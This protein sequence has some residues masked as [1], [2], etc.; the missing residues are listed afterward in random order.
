MSDSTRY[1]QVVE[2][3]GDE[4]S[5]TYLVGF[6]S[7]N[8][9]EAMHWWRERG[10]DG[11]KYSFILEYDS[12]EVVPEGHF[13]LPHFQ[14]T[15]GAWEERIKLFLYPGRP[16]AYLVYSYDSSH[17][18]M[19]LQ[20]END[21]LALAL[22][23]AAQLGYGKNIYKEEADG[24]VFDGDGDFWNAKIIEEHKLLTP[25]QI[26]EATLNETWMLT[27]LMN[28]EAQMGVIRQALINYAHAIQRRAQQGT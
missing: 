21:S 10:G 15:L 6:E 12:A 19:R 13:R 22:V 3:E 28:P 7:K 2:I 25:E 9:H 5:E 1:F 16:T 26:A 8:V 17:Q 14:G 20:Y 27:S 18:K 4:H 11:G 24:T 23:F